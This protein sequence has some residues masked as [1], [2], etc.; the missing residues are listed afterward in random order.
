MIRTAL[1]LSTVAA[2]LNGGNGPPWPTMAGDNVFD[3]RSDA[4]DDIKGNMRQPVIIVRTADDRSQVM[5]N[6]ARVDDHAVDLRIEFGVM[7]AFKTDDGSLVPDWPETDASLE[8]HVD[9]ME[10]QIRNALWGSGDWAVWYR[11]LPWRVTEVNSLPGFASVGE[12]RVRLAL[13]ELAIAQQVPRDCLPKPIKAADLALDSHGDPI[14]PTPQI[15]PT[16]RAVFDKIAADG[17]GDW[18]TATGKIHDQLFARD[19]PV[20]G[21]KPMFD[22]AIATLPRGVADSLGRRPSFGASLKDS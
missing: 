21:I 20:G 12:A 8:A 7:T 16:V 9:L 11:S 1:R 15:A 4:V 22:R 13:R 18:Q 19:I 2:L 3:S 14:P 10:L 6:V 17:G 5:G